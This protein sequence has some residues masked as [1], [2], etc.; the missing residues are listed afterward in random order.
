MFKSKFR[1]RIMQVSY[2]YHTGNMAVKKLV[3]DVST[4]LS[5]ASVNLLLWKSQVFPYVYKLKTKNT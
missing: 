1:H 3:S 2:M 4:A 5:R